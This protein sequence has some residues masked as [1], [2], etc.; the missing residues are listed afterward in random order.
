MTS[1][2]EVQF[3]R[4]DQV[5]AQRQE[6]SLVYLPVGPLEWH[7]PHLPLGVDPLRAQVAALALAKIIGGIVLP[8]LYVGTERERSP[9]ML[10]DIGFA[11]NEYVVGMDFPRNSLKSLYFKEEVF[12]LLLRNYLEML[13]DDW[14]FRN[15]IIVNGHGAENQLNVIA[16]LQREFAAR[17]AARIILVMPMLDFPN[18]KWSHATLEETETLLACFPESIALDALPP[19]DTPLLNTEWAV[20]DDLTFR[21]QP[22]EDSTVRPEEDPRRADAESGARVFGR[23]VE[24]LSSLIRARLEETA[25]SQEKAM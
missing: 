6:N 16:R 21:G 12:A 7:G 22:T 23:T 18:H 8:T 25:A 11:G 17:K 9:E 5:L 4:P 10:R 2:Q 1:S 13:I 20:V 24:Q 3:L 19:G 15:V 14:M